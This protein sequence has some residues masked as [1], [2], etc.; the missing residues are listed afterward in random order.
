MTGAEAAGIGA[1][2]VL[3]QN[4]VVAVMARPRQLVR[5]D[6]T[7]IQPIRTTGGALVAPTGIAIGPDGR[8]FVADPGAHRVWR[9][10]RTGFIDPF[11][12]DGRNGSGLETSGDRGPAIEAEC[13]SPTG[14]AVDVAGAVV[15]TDPGRD[16]VWRVGSDSRIQPVAGSGVEATTG[17]GG[18]A[19]RAAIRNPIAVAVADDGRIVIVGAEAGPLRVVGA[20]GRITSYRAASPTGRISSLAAFGRRVWAAT[21]DGRVTPVGVD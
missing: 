18:P 16:R 17:D 20:D 4:T 2:S 19:V 15:F 8:M 3:D 1:I 5:I 6:A 10:D 14:V 11:A 13:G 12:C 7:G 9:V 21:D